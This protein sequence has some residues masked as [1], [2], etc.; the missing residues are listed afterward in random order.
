MKDLLS[1]C[2]PCTAN[3]AEHVPLAVNTR[4]PENL[5]KLKG[6][7]S[8]IRQLTSRADAPMEKL[9]TMLIAR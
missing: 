4:I 1:G 7:D 5:T 6:P 3:K 8:Q 9:I 2:K